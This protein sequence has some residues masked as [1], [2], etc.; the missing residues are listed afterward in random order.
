[1]DYSY[2]I[3]SSGVPKCHSQETFKPLLKQLVRATS[4]PP[5]SSSSSTNT[6]EPILSDSQLVDLF[7]H[8]A[9]PNFTTHPENH[10]QIG[11][12]LTSLRL[13]EL[14]KRSQTFAIA[15]RIF[16]QSCI[17]VEVPPLEKS[18]G[19][20][21]PASAAAT[22]D[23]DGLGREPTYEGALDLVG[24]G[25]DGHDTFNVSTTAAMV[26]A[27][28]P[29]VRV[30]K[31]GA[32]ASSST[33][34]S[35]DLLLSLGIPLLHLPPKSLPKL[36]PRSKFSFLFAQLYHPALAPLGPIRKSLG[37]PTIFNILGPLINPARPK[38]CV[39][40]VHSHYLG[41]SYAEALRTGGVERAWV[42]CGKEGLDEISPEGETDVWEL[43]GGEIKEFT[44]SPAD[45]G[46]PA[47]PLKHV[48]SQT[49]KENASIVL[50]L[51]GERD[52]RGRK[53]ESAE[54]NE[55]DEIGFSPEPLPSPLPPHSSALQDAETKD[56]PEVPKG[57]RMKALEDYTV[58]QASALLYIG[59]FG[60]DL[61]ECASLARESM[62]GGGALEALRSF[63]REALQAVESSS[64]RD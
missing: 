21:P 2:N 54:G 26:A 50:H 44:I 61:K 42:V 17:P 25:G 30:C 63:R 29:G 13:T 24:T 48:G 5:S 47:H 57:V 28:V 59:G 1:M 40:G 46:V 62:R 16:L 27:G 45:F 55:E 64:N 32:K 11:S 4:S 58:L 39:L 41:R 60:S 56:L 34:G 49:S 12:A 51:F 20:P 18:L 10:A 8:L 53:G 9:D 35:A 43:K 22:S 7:E 33:S 23:H 52:A 6:P 14:D 37:F 36:L 38:R 19:S 31:H 15:S 3:S